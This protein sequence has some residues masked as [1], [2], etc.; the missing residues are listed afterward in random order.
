M[1][2]ISI[3]ITESQAQ[4]VAGIPKTITLTT[5]IHS[6]IFYTLDG[7]DPNLFSTIYT[8]PI[9]MPTNLL[10]ITL[11]VFASNG[12]DNSPIVTETY[13][14]NEVDGNTR[15]ARHGTT[16][17]ANS[18]ASNM[19]PFGDSQIDPTVQFTD[20][21]NTGINVN[22]PNLP[23]A[24]TGYDAN[25]QPTGQTNKPYNFQNYDIIYPQGNS[26]NEPLKVGQLPSKI[27]T[28][29]RVDL[30]ESSSY[31]SKYFDPKAFVIYQD[32]STED[33]SKPPL[34]NRAHFSGELHERVRTGN[35]FFVSGL[36]APPT[37]GAFVRSAYNARENTITYY[38][39]DQIANKW[40]ISKQAYQPKDPD[41]GALYQVKFARGTQTA[42]LVFKWIPFARRVLF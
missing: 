22:D 17:Q 13:F 7:S 26:I 30:P 39:Y 28:R 29:P 21:G 31:G 40:I 33:P 5:N 42:G 38:Y 15:H 23:N 24:P 16:A 36:D 4:I 19:Y 1:A 25:A 35:N 10:S 2:I 18:A 34:I 9:T 37:T 27:T 12:T 8:G 6:S 3:S 41:A 20:P 11:K 14:T 32:A